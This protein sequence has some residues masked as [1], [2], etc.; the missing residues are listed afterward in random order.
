MNPLICIAIAVVAVFTIK[1]V[2]AAPEECLA[3][4]GSH[5]PFLESLSE[6]TTRNEWAPL[7]AA[8][9]RDPMRFAHPLQPALPGY[10]ATITLCAAALEDE[11]GV[12]PLRAALATVEASLAVAEARAARSADPLTGASGLVGSRLATARVRRSAPF[13]PRLTP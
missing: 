4:I 2:L 12:E 11:S 6:T 8:I 13:A 1:P 3:K 10:L 5:S 7:R 9:E